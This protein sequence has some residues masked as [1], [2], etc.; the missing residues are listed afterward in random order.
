MTTRFGNYKPGTGNPNWKPGQSGNPS[1]GN[2]HMRLTRAHQKDMAE[3]CA[4]KGI[5]PVEFMLKILWDPKQTM[6][7]RKWAAQQAAPYIHPRLAQIDH[8]V[9]KNVVYHIA[10]KPI[11]LDE[12][13]AKWTDVEP[14]GGPT[15]KPN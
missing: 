3:E 12:W 9:E 6:E 8:N 5:T 14:P 13:A 4:K 10:D 15:S 11:T 2:A 7:N 1:G